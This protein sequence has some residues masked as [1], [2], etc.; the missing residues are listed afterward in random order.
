MVAFDPRVALRILREKQRRLDN[1]AFEYLR[2]RF[3]HQMEGGWYDKRFYELDALYEAKSK[4]AG[5]MF[6]VIDYLEDRIEAEK[7]REERIWDFLRGMEANTGVDMVKDVLWL[8][9]VVDG[10]AEF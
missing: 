1:E 3:E 7:S 5:S 9:D 6:D 4:E 10:K 2:Q 8:A